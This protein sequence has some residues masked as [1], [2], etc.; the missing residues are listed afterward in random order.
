VKGVYLAEANQEIGR[1]RFRFESVCTDG[2]QENRGI[3]ILAV[4]LLLCIGVRMSRRTWQ[5]GVGRVAANPERTRRK[6][7]VRLGV[8]TTLAEL[9]SR[10]Q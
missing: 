8:K 9:A 6:R 5:H 4:N 10:R 7:N 2:F 1:W 3:T